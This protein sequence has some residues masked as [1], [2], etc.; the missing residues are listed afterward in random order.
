MNPDDT[1]PREDPGRGLF[2]KISR[3]GFL[4][5][6]TG[7]MAGGVIG[8]ALDREGKKG[9][10]STQSEWGD[11][12][13]RLRE[14]GIEI[15]RYPVG[16][17]NAITDVEGVKVG[18]RTKIEGSGQLKVG[19]GPIRTGVTA[20]IPHEGNIF[21]EKLAVGHF[22]LNGNGEM[23]GFVRNRERGLLE[24]PIFLTGTAN[25]G[26]VYDA[27]LTHLIKENP[28]IGES[29]KV[30]IPVVAECWDG[31]GDTEGRH[32][33]EQ[34]VIDAIENAAGGP[35]AEGVVG[36]GTGMRSYGF[37]GGIGT[38]SR[39]LPEERGGY[40][41]GVLVNANHSGRHLLR[42]D[43][44]PVGR[45]LIDYPE[46]EIKNKSIILVAATDAPMLPVQLQRLC[47]RM[48][49][50][51]ARTGSVSTHGSG[52][53]FI[54]FS[55]GNK[56]TDASK[57]LRF[58]DDRVVSRIWEATVEATEEAALNALIAAPSMDGVNGVVRHGI[59]LDR[60]I[61]VMKK[62]KRLK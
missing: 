1:N 26:I 9:I 8:Y 57:A 31:M 56:I 34:D 43:G 32:I 17:F 41:V 37:K 15:G 42:V 47:K 13:A 30:P 35:V 51:L 53:I 44:V 29:E 18:H 23:T 62:Y 40:T 55:T 6:S 28:G 45:E 19:V 7:S 61:N 58:V 38:S 20:I 21:Q 59:P 36:G 48:S 16:A 12:R 52:D 46:E 2:A 27:A 33:T 4:R 14:I 49:M 54:A 11:R 25:I 39:I 5:V 22:V 50:G 60:L 24:T 10:S 3:R